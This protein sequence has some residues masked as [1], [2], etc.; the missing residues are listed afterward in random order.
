[1]TKLKTVAVRLTPDEY[2]WVSEQSK[3]SGRSRGGYLAWLVRAAAKVVKE[4][5]EFNVYQTDLCD[6][7]VSV[8]TSGPLTTEAASAPRLGEPTPEQLAFRKRMLSKGAK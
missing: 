6:R 4:A 5:N 2:E 7:N 8:D 3:I 1:M